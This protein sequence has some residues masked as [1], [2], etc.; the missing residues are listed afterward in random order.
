MPC[1]G[2]DGKNTD[3]YNF[4]KLKRKSKY[5]SNCQA[6]LW[7]KKILIKSLRKHESAWQFE[8]WSSFRSKKTNNEYYAWI[9]TKNYVL[10]YNWG[11]AASGGMCNIEEIRRLEHKTG[12]DFNIARENMKH[13]YEFNKTK[14]K[15]N[16]LS[17]ES[18][19]IIISRIK[20]II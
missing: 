19:K 18:W 17:K 2:G 5:R 10:P 8:R 14:R 7:N 1:D 20:S 9:G 11:K 12:I 3:Y 13:D 4:E 6:G 15:K 16:I